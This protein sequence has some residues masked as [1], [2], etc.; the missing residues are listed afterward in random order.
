MLCQSKR[1]NST[2]DTIQSDRESS[3]CMAIL[4]SLSPLLLLASSASAEVSDAVAYNNT[5]QEETLKNAAGVSYILLVA[6]FLYRLLRR[7]AKRAKEE[8]LSGQET[9]PSLFD[10]IREK[11]VPSNPTKSDEVRDATPLD[12][13]IGAAQAGGIGFGLFIFSSKMTALIGQQSL[14]DAYTARNITITVRTILQGL[15]WL[16]TFIFCLNAVGLFGLSIQMMIFPD[17]LREDEEDRAAKRAA[18][19]AQGPQLPKVAMTAN[20]SDVRRAFDQAERMGKDE[21]NQSG[22]KGQNDS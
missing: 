3:S 8:K 15:T 20:P 9:G 11:V 6:W 10:Y 5:A 17:S 22:D 12:A 4:S 18:R 16:A 13:L 1:N 21:G 7:R 14:P 2:V 19:E